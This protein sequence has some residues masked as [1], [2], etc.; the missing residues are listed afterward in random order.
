MATES[1]NG[2]TAAFTKESLSMDQ[3]MEMEFINGLTDG[4]TAEN[5]KMESNMELVSLLIKM[6]SKEQLNVEMEKRSD[7]WIK[8]LIMQH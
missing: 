3:D 7:G 2:Q 4:R 6:A 1:L 5:G 8:E